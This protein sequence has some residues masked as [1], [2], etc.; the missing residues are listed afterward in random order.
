M[1]DKDKAIVTRS[2]GP[3]KE[4]S[5]LQTLLREIRAVS[6]KIEKVEQQMISKVDALQLSLERT[7]REELKQL[8]DNFDEE[9]GSL[10][11]AAGPLR[12]PPRRVEL[13]PRGV[14]L[15]PLQE[16]KHG[17]AEELLPTQ[18]RLNKLVRR[19]NSTLG[20]S[21]DSVEEVR[22]RRPLDSVEEVRNR[23]LLDSVE[24]VR[25]RRPL[26][27][28]EEVRDRRPLDSVEE[29]R[30]RRPLDSVE[31]VRDRRP[32][33]SVEVV[34]DRRPLDSVEEV[35]DRRPLDSVEEVRDRRPLDSVEERLGNAQERL[36]TTCSS[37]KETGEVFGLRYGTTGTG[38]STDPSSAASKR[39]PQRNQREQVKRGLIQP[40]AIV[41]EPL[42]NI[43]IS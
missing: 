20:C 8:K 23:R 29:V 39:S 10:K 21:L 31:E 35:R 28:V 1:A 38:R 16:T 43:E 5:G 42:Q 9:I 33:D 4:D 32:L 15:R 19:A 26:D 18:N 27:S 24:V 36:N 41:K 2:R 11:C 14:E 12:L 34:R 17:D 13:P 30:D 25:D 3:D 6:S 40:K 22:D 7:L 37:S